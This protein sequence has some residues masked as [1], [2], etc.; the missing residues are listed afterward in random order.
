LETN[1]ITGIFVDNLGNKTAITLIK[2]VKEAATRRVIILICTKK[3]NKAAHTAMKMDIMKR[4]QSV[5][6]TLQ[7]EDPIL[8]S[9]DLLNSFYL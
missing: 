6:T 3:F 8:H 9:D 4:L 1:T 7:E 2:I 5:F